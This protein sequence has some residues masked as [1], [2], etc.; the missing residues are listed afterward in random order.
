MSHI[1]AMDHPCAP[2]FKAANGVTALARALKLSHTT[3]L[4]WQQVPAKHVREVARVTRLPLHELRPDL[5]DA[6]RRRKPAVAV[7]QPE[8][9]A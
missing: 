3:L 6:P 5:Y 9:V 2:V 4:G 8:G 1:L 7:P